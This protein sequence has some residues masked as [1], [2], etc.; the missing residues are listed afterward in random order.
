M[1]KA[2]SSRTKLTLLCLQD[3]I[4]EVEPRAVTAVEAGRRKVDADADTDRAISVAGE[5]DEV[6]EAMAEWYRD[7]ST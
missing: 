6:E 1:E 7:G 4:I 2:S 3:I 5:K